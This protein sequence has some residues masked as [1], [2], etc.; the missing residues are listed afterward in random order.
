LEDLYKIEKMKWDLIKRNKGK[1]LEDIIGGKE[2]S[3]ELGTF[4]HLSNSF[5]K[6]VSLP[7]KERAEES[8][9]KDF[10]LIAGVGPATTKKFIDQGICDMLDLRQYQR[11]CS[12]VET[13]L[14]VV[15]KG[16][17]IELQSLV[18]RWH[19]LS[20]PLCY[21]L[22]GFA[23]SEDLLFF[24]IETMG[25]RFRPLFLIGIGRL[26]KG[27]FVVEQFFA[28]DTS[29]EMAVIQ[30]FLNRLSADTILVSF[31]GRSFDSRFIKERMDMHD[32]KGFEDMPHFD[33][34]HMC[35]GRW[36]V[37]N[38]RLVTLERCVLEE[39]RCSDVSSA[40]VPH[41]YELYLRKKNAG[42]IIPI[43]EHN[44]RDI[45]SMVSLLNTIAEDELEG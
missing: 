19:P 6:N 23:D 17:L 25:L 45:V 28:R 7:S 12:K 2:R 40:M 16:D 35:R 42:P 27:K 39:E 22:T 8:I 9:L 5:E 26:D 11:W 30:E 24:D 37:P 29:E 36:K 44:K 31:N 21:M 20:H 34:L 15:E 4:H 33:L 32:L 3:N 38:N 43:I 13:I 18:E 41:F 1:N 10:D 14:D